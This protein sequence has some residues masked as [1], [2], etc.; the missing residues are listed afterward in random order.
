M[1]HQQWQKK[2]ILGEKYHAKAG[3]MNSLEMESLPFRFS[4]K[5][6]PSIYF[7]APQNKPS[8]SHCSKTDR[9]GEI[10]QEKKIVAPKR[11]CPRVFSLQAIKTK[12]SVKS[13]RA[14]IV[15]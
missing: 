9:E 8:P 2:T 14:P 12:Q 4:L 15:P 6:S 1:Q 10:L 5:V 3:G 11:L 13:I 7:K